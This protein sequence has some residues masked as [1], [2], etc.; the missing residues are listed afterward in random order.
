[1]G[2]SG[3]S[4][5]TLACPPPFAESAVSAEIDRIRREE[6][7]RGWDLNLRLV[8]RSRLSAREFRWLLIPGEGAAVL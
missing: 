1:M 7:Q 2:R 4:T 3:A 6:F 5:L 8:R